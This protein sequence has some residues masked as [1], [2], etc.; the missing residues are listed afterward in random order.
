MSSG[1]FRLFQMMEVYKIVLQYCWSEK[2]HCFHIFIEIL[3]EIHC[4]HFQNLNTCSI[5]NMIMNIFVYTLASSSTKRNHF[6]WRFCWIL[7]LS[8][9]IQ[10]IIFLIRGY[11]RPIGNDST[12]FL[13]LFRNKYKNVVFSKMINEPFHTLLSPLNW[14]R[15]P[16]L[17]FW[18]FN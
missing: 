4:C 7:N 5:I 17:S 12:T 2:L 11:S 15:T 16:W 10:K 1:Y 13:M 14:N 18:I 9:H 8:Y 6:D 3:W